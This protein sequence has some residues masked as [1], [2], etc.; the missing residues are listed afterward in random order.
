MVKMISL[1]MIYI[2]KN[3][4]R[5]CNKNLLPKIVKFS[6]ETGL[7]KPAIVTSNSYFLPN[8]G[9]NMSFVSK[10]IEVDLVIK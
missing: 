10:V 9:H 7:W 2:V 5:K 8:L 1:N 6:C 3:G 4:I